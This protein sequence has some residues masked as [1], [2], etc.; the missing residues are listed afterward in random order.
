M[1]E[2]RTVPKILAEL[3]TLAAFAT[4]RPDLTFY[5]T[6]I[7]TGEAGLSPL[8]MRRAA[9]KANLPSNVLPW[10]TWDGSEAPATPAVKQHSIF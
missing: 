4:A 6:A 7:G 1:L 5:L 3:I 2:A 10:W 8:V 9:I